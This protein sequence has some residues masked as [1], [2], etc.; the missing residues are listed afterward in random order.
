MRIN[1]LIDDN[2]ATDGKF[3]ISSGVLNNHM[4]PNP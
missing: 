1:L 2:L 3:S 4:D